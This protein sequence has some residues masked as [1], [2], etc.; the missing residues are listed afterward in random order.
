MS[1]KTGTA[2]NYFDLLTTLRDFLVDQG[3]AWGLAYAGVGD[4]RIYDAIGTAATV[5]ETITCTATSPTSFDVVGS[6]SG[7]LGAAAVDDTF[8]CAVCEFDL[9]SGSTPFVAGDEFTFNLSPKWTQ[10]RWGGCSDDALRTASAGTV[11]AFFN[12][13]TNVNAVSA[14][15][16]FTVAV[17]MQA[18]I[19]VKAFSIWNGTAANGPT[20]FALEYSDNG[21]SWTAA[22]SWSS[23]TWASTN[24]RKDYV[25]SSSAGSH[26]HWR[27]NV[28]AGS[29]TTQITE[30][31]FYADTAFKWACSNSFEFAFEAPGVDGTQ[32]INVLGRLAV[33]AGTGYWNIGWRGVRFWTDQNLSVSS[34]PGSSSEHIHPANNGSIQYW[35]VAN[36]GRF[37]LAT[38]I[39][40]VYSFTYCGFGLPYE[41]PTNHPY[42]CI[43]GAPSDTATILY[44]NS[45]DAGYRN[46]N[47]PGE[48]GVDV[49]IPSGQWR[50]LRNRADTSTPPDG[51]TGGNTYGKVWPWAATDTGDQG[52]STLMR[53]AVDGSKP[54]MPAVILLPQDDHA[55]GEFEGVH[56]TSGFGNTAESLAQIGAIDYLAFPNVYRSGVNHFAAIALD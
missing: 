11:S 4:G 7:A 32:E 2:S 18:A 6:V 36:G 53:D 27:L 35:M 13:V 15:T 8:T 24:Q 14:A 37:I 10:L 26:V 54:I 20:A 40:G 22:Q 30:L 19:E 47:D 17:Q 51:N 23:Q 52:F 43:I 1:V 33:N 41:T 50:E 21:S 16:P 29:A 39:S 5:V 49:M 28:T 38:R 3:H 55:W 45:S 34:V 42:P 25:L 44:S 31:A 46:P 48:M 12:G 9:L 56:W